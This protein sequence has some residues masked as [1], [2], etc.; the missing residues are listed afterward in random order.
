MTCFVI[1]LSLREKYSNTVFFLVR[2][3]TLFTQC[4]NTTVTSKLLVSRYPY[5]PKYICLIKDKKKGFGQALFSCSRYTIDRFM[6]IYCN[7]FLFKIYDWPSHEN[8]LASTNQDSVLL[9]F[10]RIQKCLSQLQNIFQLKIKLRIPNK[11]RKTLKA[12]G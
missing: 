10:G 6:N 7:V 8:F 1:T 4:I 2:I 12:M 5:K 9:A 3:W 11:A